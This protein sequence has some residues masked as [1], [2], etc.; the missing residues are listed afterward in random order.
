MA[1][2]NTHPGG[3]ASMAARYLAKDGRVSREDIAEVLAVHPTAITRWLS[4]AKRVHAGAMIETI[5]YL[6]GHDP[7]H[8]EDTATDD[9]SESERDDLGFAIALVNLCDAAYL[10]NNPGADRVWDLQE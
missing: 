4:G 2:S 5:L 1:T 9:L 3:R 6:R 10:K 7:R 8:V